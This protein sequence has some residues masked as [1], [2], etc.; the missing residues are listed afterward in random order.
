MMLVLGQSLSRSKKQEMGFHASYDQFIPALRSGIG[1]S[2]N[3]GSSSFSWEDYG[4]TGVN[5][6]TTFNYSGLTL[7]IAPKFSIKGKYTL[8]PSIDFSYGYG[9]AETKLPEVSGLVDLEG[10]HM[11]VES[12]LGLLFNT[13]KYY[14]GLSTTIL[15][16]HFYDNQRYRLLNSFITYFQAGYTF[17]KSATSRFSFT[18]QV[19][20]R[21]S[22]NE[23]TP[24]TEYILHSGAAN[25]TFRYD[26]Y[27]AGFSNTG[28]HLGLQTKKL[29]VMLS[30][31]PFRSKNKFYENGNLSF[32][33]IFRE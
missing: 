4:G 18:P 15:D 17:Q 19:A 10:Q 25:F 22:A 21:I 33:Y 12:R 2:V 6:S 16:Q 27:I 3:N 14:A 32:R 13:S 20:Y 31:N 5:Y 9:K 24:F 1:V 8:S 7:A 28:I 26:S 29:R 11:W 23:S 30:N